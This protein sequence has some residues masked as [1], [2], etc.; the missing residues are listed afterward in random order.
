MNRHARKVIPPRRHHKPPSV[1][2][3]QKSG[4]PRWILPLALITVLG[5]I[6]FLLGKYFEINYPDPFD[7]GMY[8]YSAKYIL[9]GAK[10]GVDEIPSAQ[11]GTMLVNILGVRLG[12]FNETGPKIIQGF[13]QAAALVLMFIA[14]K[15]LFGTLAGAVGV[16]MASV[17]LSA[18]AIAKFGNVKEQH[19]IAFMVIGASCFVLYQLNGK[20]WLAVLAGAFVSWAPLFKQ[21]G[22]TVIGAIGLFVVAQ[23]IL[24]NRTLRQTGADILLLLAGVT[25]AIAPLYL[26]ILIWDVKL[27]LPYS[28]VWTTI[29]H[30]LPAKAASAG[31]ATPDYVSAGRKAV[32]LAKQ[33]PM[34][35]RYYGLLILPVALAACSIV[36]RLARV[37][38]GRL[39]GS[40]A[41]A[42]PYDRFVLLFGLWW[43]LDMA[44]VWISP[45]PYEQYY[46]PLNASAAMLG[47]YTVGLYQ[48]KVR[49]AASKPPWLA[50]GALGLLVM[51]VLSWHMFFGVTRSPATGADY[52]DRDG[53]LIRQRG[54][55]QKW[56]DIHL[57]KKENLIGYW[58]IA[59][60]YIRQNSEPT[61][62]IYVWGWI[63]G[64]YVRAQRFSS[65]SSACTSEM[66]VL[67]P[68]AL[69]TMVAGLLGAFE[70]QPPRF[71]V[72]THN[73]HFPYDGRPPLELWPRPPKAWVAPEGLTKEGFLRPDNRAAVEK[74]EAQYGKALQEKQQTWA[75]E[76][77]RFE[78][79][80]PLR[81]YV[82]NNYRIVQTFGD[83]ALFELKKPAAAKTE[84]P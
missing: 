83:L 10:I 17:Y 84:G 66:Q 7:S 36:A 55:S 82:M 28:F 71:I 23:P 72:D 61:D 44:F 60:D 16:I 45:R 75:D 1:Q 49:S 74:Y 59:G 48:D 4:I 46:L 34:V 24:R 73:P 30:M 69:S 43:L 38:Q 27:P 42:K 58:E 77:Q 70:K 37:I 18:P 54:Y 63:P 52:R 79:M 11:I 33:A 19:M 26:W 20:W 22:T 67:P 25:A 62:K 40:Q 14:M 2:D 15:K 5:G 35:F 29:A 3:H 21:T 12:G 6:P 78:A 32:P 68:P 65:A 50:A 57:R 76:A 41:A 47:G 8:V 39:R 51:M 31:G 81:Q 80:K 53:R 9:A 56:D 64:I 13:L